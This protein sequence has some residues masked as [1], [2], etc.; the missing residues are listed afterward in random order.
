[1]YRLNGVR[2]TARG[3]LKGTENQH[4]YDPEESSHVYMVPSFEDDYCDVDETGEHTEPI[5]G[6]FS[7]RVHKTILETIKF[8]AIGAFPSH[9][10]TDSNLPAYGKSISAYWKGRRREACACIMHYCAIRK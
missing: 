10:A 6:N 4:A 5:K 3:H 2:L 8:V 7:L 1:M 9:K